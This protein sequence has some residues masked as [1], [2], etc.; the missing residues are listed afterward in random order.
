LLIDDEVRKAEAL[1]NYFREVCAWNA[2]IAGGPG[3]ALEL[4]RIENEC[5]YDVIIL[6]VMMDPGETIP[7]ELTNGGRDTGLILLEAIFKL[8][9]GKVLIVLYSARTDLD[10]LKSDGR[11]AAYIQK[12]ASARE[13]VREIERL[14][15]EPAL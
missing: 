15:S 12:P 8:T 4:L 2:Q 10:H 13:I 14:L 5:P 6:D 7:R 3:Q 1:I 11:I 9:C